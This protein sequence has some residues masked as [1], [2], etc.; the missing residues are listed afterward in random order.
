MLTWCVLPVVDTVQ[1]HGASTRVNEAGPNASSVSQS[2]VRNPEADH[3]GAHGSIWLGGDEAH[4][5]VQVRKTVTWVGPCASLSMSGRHR[6]K[7]A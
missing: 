4:Q 5:V 2:E 6:N 1:H 7:C 3:L